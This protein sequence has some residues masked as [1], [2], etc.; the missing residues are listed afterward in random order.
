[1]IY[2]ISVTVALLIALAGPALGQAPNFLPKMMPIIC[3]AKSQFGATVAKK[4]K[5]F[6]IGV[7][8]ALKSHIV[9]IWKT[10]KT[11]GSW[12]ITIRSAADSEIC[13]I[14]A[15][16]QMVPADYFTESGLPR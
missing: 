8:P 2:K 9:E 12:T 11:D 16:S 6:L 10:P 14:A 13:I 4:E 3:M 7:M 1:M 5:V 15:G